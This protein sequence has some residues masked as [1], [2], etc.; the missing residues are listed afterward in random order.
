MKYGAQKTFNHLREGKT[1]TQM[2]FVK[3][4]IEE[5]DIFKLEMWKCTGEQTLE[6]PMMK[7]M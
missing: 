4:S 5:S 3:W 6:C 7:T 1:T 2:N